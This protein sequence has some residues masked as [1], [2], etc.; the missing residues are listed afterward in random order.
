MGEFHNFLASPNAYTM[1]Q[2]AEAVLFNVVHHASTP[3]RVRRTVR[4]IEEFDPL[5]VFTDSSGFQLLQAQLKRKRCT[6]VENRPVK[7]NG[8]LNLTPRHVVEAVTNL[9]ARIRAA[10]SMAALDFPIRK[11][12]DGGAQ[13]REF[14][15]KLAYNVLWADQTA[16][17]RAVFCP[18]VQL[19]IP[20]Q[21]YNL[22]QFEVFYDRL[23]SREVPFDGLCMPLRNL[24]LHEVLLFLA[25]FRQLGIEKVHLLGSSPFFIMA[26]GTYMAQHHFDWLSLDATNWQTNARFGIY[27]N[28]Y[29]LSNENLG[30]S[31][32][33]DES[34]VNDCA[35]P[36][37]RNMTFTGIKNLPRAEQMSLLVQHN[38][39]AM[40]KA[41][42]A[43]IQ[44]AVDLPTLE[45]YL[46]RVSKRKDKARDLCTWLSLFEVGKDWDTG[47][48]AVMLRP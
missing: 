24:K 20:V 26:L 47:E 15:E 1:P 40:E 19:F 28:P 42:K 13:D 33:V 36:W 2:G 30:E 38:Y 6:F 21:A 46:V 35:C 44:H 8:C 7:Y 16:R 14:R 34:I 39:W 43:L 29:D 4:L 9:K 41:R 31:V 11:F 25:R 48:L 18:D 10:F 37:C 23:R 22:A 12:T 3:R 45:K 32:V 5:H 17:L 27:M